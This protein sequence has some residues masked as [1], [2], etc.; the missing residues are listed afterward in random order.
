MENAEGNR[1]RIELV[2]HDQGDRPPFE[3]PNGCYFLIFPENQDNLASRAIAAIV[4][5]AHA[6]PDYAIELPKSRATTAVTKDG[7]GMV[8]VWSDE[9]WALAG[10]TK[11]YL[12]TLR[13]A[14]FPGPRPLKE[15]E[16]PPEAAALWNDILRMAMAAKVKGLAADNERG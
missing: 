6:N 5:T 9:S 2:V 3:A 12:Q 8:A 15:H 11:E 14:I 16:L 7:K 10:E 4:A 1:E 13:D